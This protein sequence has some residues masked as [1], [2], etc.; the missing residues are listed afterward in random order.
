MRIT[1]VPGEFA[2]WVGALDLSNRWELRASKSAAADLRIALAAGAD[3]PVLFVP[4]EA[5]VP[6]RLQQV[7]VPHDGTPATTLALDTASEIVAGSR[8]E[9]VVLHV[10]APEFPAEPGSLP[11]PRLVDHVSYDLPEWRDEFSRRF[12]HRSL[13]LLLR[14]EVSVGP[15][16]ESILDA[17]RRLPADLL[18]LGWQGV[19][20][21]GRATTVRSVCA[22]SPCPVLLVAVTPGSE[23]VAGYR[24]AGS[25]G[26]PG[27][28]TE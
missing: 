20:E 26:M 27:T 12:L 1:V 18:V 8:V 19:L 10:A 17:A 23:P 5:Q 15:V 22:A 6:D 3:S 16:A 13:G 21:E 2:Q 28:L 7:L 9:V 14:L 24:A 11:A 25:W 4:E